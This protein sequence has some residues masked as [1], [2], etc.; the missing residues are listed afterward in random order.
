MNLNKIIWFF[1][2]GLI[3]T[4][5]NCGCIL[6]LTT[7]KKA[8][9]V[10][11]TCLWLPCN[12]FTFIHSSAFVGVFRIFFLFRNSL[13]R[14]LLTWRIWWASNNASRW[15]MGFNS[16]FKGL[17]NRDSSVSIVSIPR[18]GRPR[19]CPSIPGRG[20]SLLRSYQSSRLP[21]VP[22]WVPFRPLFNAM[23]RL[24]PCE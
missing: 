22:L 11:E 2:Y 14:I 24:F 10:A 18:A 15:Q 19:N 7:L 13:T 23:Q 8:T 1:N 5:Y 3:P 21:W 12:K 17:M 20:K 9:W 16:A 6:V 4:N